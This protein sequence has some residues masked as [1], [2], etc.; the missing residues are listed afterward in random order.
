MSI[1]GFL[2]FLGLVVAIY[3]LLSVVSRYRFRLHG[4]WLWVP[5][6]TAL[7]VVVYLLLFD[8]VGILCTASWCHS[9]TLSQERGLTP[10]K[11][12]F[13]VVLLWLSYIALLAR[14]KAVGKGQLPLLSA[15]VDRL[16]AEKRYP[17]L[18]DFIEPQINLISRCAARQFP[19]QKLRDRVR[20]H[21]SPFRPRDPPAK[22]LSKLERLRQTIA[23]WCL[24]ALKPILERIPESEAHEEAAQ[25]IL[26]VLHTNDLLVEFVAL[27]RPLFALKLM[28]TGVYD[29][30]F[31]DR[32]FDLMMAH[33]ASQFRREILLNQVSQNCFFLIDPKNPVIHALFVDARV[34][35]KFEVWRPVGNFPIRLLERDVGGYRQAISAKKPYENALIHR[36]PTYTMIRFF[37]LMV[38]SAMRDAI[39]WHMWLFYFDILI[40]KLLKSMDRKH[41]DYAP[42]AEFP[43]FGYYLI[44]EI[45][46]AYGD[47]LRAVECCAEDSPAIEIQ[48]TAPNHEN[49]SI[50]KSTILSI[51]N[52]L[53][54]LLENDDTPDAVITYLL[55]MTMRD[56]RDLANRKN[57]GALAQEALRNS[58][59][60]GGYS[61]LKDIQIARLGDC[62]AE[63]D[64]LLQFETKDFADALAVALQ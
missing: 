4:F 13:V 54:H 28:N 60:N 8:L 26:L 59:L 62:Y 38:R 47:W 32:A 29:D 6:L 31:G 43:N 1:D 44:F 2:G 61:E 48:S 7:S 46:G 49:G 57:G 52:S 22:R 58:I 39:K 24:G 15:L 63:I 10:N 12:A 11:L 41:P 18:V 19:F 64:P 51:G 34:A 27:E 5:T 17:E 25:R 21:G 30:E 36:D 40:E 3:A 37:D 14:H 20:W 53:R 16:V 9:F 35:E 55:G 42:D 45:F 50:F 33:P 56:Y 23:P